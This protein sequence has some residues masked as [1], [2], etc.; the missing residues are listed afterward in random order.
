MTR[1]EFIERL[2][3]K[4]INP[5]MVSFNDD[6]K[7]GRCIRKNYHRWETLMRERGEEYDVLSFP[8]ESDALERMYSVLV[9]IYTRIRPDYA[10]WS[11]P[12]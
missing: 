9:D 5:Y 6:T 1:E 12:Q 11:N 8:S 3:E 2:K 7:E 4:G 10:R